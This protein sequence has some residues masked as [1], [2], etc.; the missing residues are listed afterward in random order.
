MPVKVFISGTSEEYGSLR[1]KLGALLR[2]MPYLDIHPV[3]QEEF[4]Q[5][6][7]VPTIS[8]IIEELRRCELVIG[9]V[10]CKGGYPRDA[11]ERKKVQEIAEEYLHMQL[12]HP[13]G[14][15][16]EAWKQQDRGMTYTQLEFF[17]AASA[18]QKGKWLFLP[19]DEKGADEYQLPYLQFIKERRF[20]LVY[21]PITADIK[22]ECLKLMVAFAL[23]KRDAAQPLSKEVPTVEAL[24]RQLAILEDRAE[25]D[26]LNKNDYDRFYETV[27]QRLC[28]RIPVLKLPS[29]P[30]S[31]KSHLP[32]HPALV[33]Y[34]QERTTLA[35]RSEQEIQVLQFD[36][37]GKRLMFRSFGL[38]AQHHP[39]SLS[40]DGDAL[41][42]LHANQVC[43][44]VGQQQPRQVELP[45][46]D[47]FSV[48]AYPALIKDGHHIW[49]VIKRHYDEDWRYIGP[50]SPPPSCPSHLTPCYPEVVFFQTGSVNVDT[51]DV[52]NASEA[53]SMP[54]P[55]YALMLDG[56][57][58]FVLEDR[59]ESTG[60]EW[61]ACHIFSVCSI[62]DLFLVDDTTVDAGGFLQ[63][64]I[65]QAKSGQKQLV[66]VVTYNCGDDM[67]TGRTAH[68]RLA[69]NYQSSPPQI[70]GSGHLTYITG[71]DFEIKAPGAH[72]SRVKFPFHT[73]YTWS[74]DAEFLVTVTSNPPP[75]SG[76]RIRAW[77]FPRPINQQEGREFIIRI[78]QYLQGEKAFAKLASTGE[79][80]RQYLRAIPG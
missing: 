51:S 62:H 36:A 75:E 34:H 8:Q 71:K 15:F 74:S 23:R 64:H 21:K 67:H 77:R 9:L 70:N 45:K 41:L 27:W 56:A 31:I 37:A 65:E 4:E 61:L 6:P 57:R 78:T 2:S 76:F 59:A 10:G 44:A 54:I 26:R 68:V 38:D 60:D 52:P 63:M 43:L 49:A 53:L 22:L 14:D 18:F 29:D 5:Y 32:G 1:D 47:S 3:I 25:H 50:E 40:T 13:P 48:H 20:R 69:D 72:E 55:H 58:A 16:W 35:I 19:R 66:C 24:L 12:Q 80:L 17:L 7:D 28:E 73:K 11:G 42:T 39:I 30:E 46:L 33:V 79:E